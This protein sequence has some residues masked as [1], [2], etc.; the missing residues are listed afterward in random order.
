[1]PETPITPEPVATGSR[2][3]ERRYDPSDSQ[4]VKVRHTFAPDEPVAPQEQSAASERGPEGS[5]PGVTDVQVV[6]DGPSAWD[7]RPVDDEE[8]EAGR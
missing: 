6:P 8:D 2:R 7:A 4:V 1:M 3:E 5:I